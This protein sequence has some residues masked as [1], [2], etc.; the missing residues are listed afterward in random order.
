V[1]RAVIQDPPRATAITAA[2][3]PA[4]V[5]TVVRSEEALE[6]RD[7]PDAL[8]EL[9]RRTVL[10]AN[11]A[12]VAAIVA[13]VAA[14]ALT[15]VGAPAYLRAGAIVL[16][17]SAAAAAVA[18]RTH[19][20]RLRAVRLTAAAALR[21]AEE[22]RETLAQRRADAE[23]SSRARNMFLASMSHE[24]RTP[25]NAIIGYGEMLQEDAALLTREQ[26][27]NDLRRITAAGKHLLGLINEL[28]DLSRIE[29]GK[30]TVHV[31]RFDIAT[32]LR[33]VAYTARPL[34][35]RQGNRLELHAAEAGAMRADITK[36]RQILLN[37]LSNAAKFTRD[38]TI[39]LS[40]ARERD[41]AIGGREQ[42]VARVADTGIGM[43]AEQ[44]GRL[45]QP[46][47]QASGSTVRDHGGTG[48]GLALTRRLCR[49]MG[50]D[51]T[52]ESE[53][54]RG[55][56]FTVRLPAVVTD[57]RETT[58]TVA[59]SQE[60]EPEGARTSAGGGAAGRG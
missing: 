41:E 45:F 31:E 40:V 46:F 4:D 8:G 33:E 29:A 11:G 16:A 7:V 43:T 44:L 38:G 3:P 59:F 15:G 35:E 50:G 39:T 27:T 22:M 19:A 60:P 26:M 28:L 5:P 12:L 49:L 52:A 55:T 53:P 1:V 6:A 54:G 32:V 24:L 36:F 10:A 2:P 18:A 48:L 51:I 14:P 9:E 20:E 58:T 25:L 47:V 13:A 23:A 37:L 42:V 17:L 30:M 21:R 34:V 56:T 57:R